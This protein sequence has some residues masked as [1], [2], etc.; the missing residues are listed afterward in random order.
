[1]GVFEADGKKI[2]IDADKCIACGACTEACPMNVLEVVGDICEAPRVADCCQCQTCV[3][4]CPVEAITTRTLKVI[5]STITVDDLRKYYKNKSLVASCLKMNN[6]SPFLITVDN[7]PDIQHLCLGMNEFTHFPNT[8]SNHS[9]L[10]Y[11]DF[12]FNKISDVSPLIDCGLLQTLIL[13]H[14]NIQ[15]IECISKINTLNV[16]DVSYNEI[17]TCVFDSLNRLGSLKINNN[18]LTSLTSSGPLRTLSISNNQLTLIHLQSTQL[19]SLSVCDNP[20]QTIDLTIPS[21]TLLDLSGT[22]IQST[23]M[24]LPSLF[25]LNLISCNLTSL[26]TEFH[27]LKSLTYLSLQGC[28]LSEL[29]DEITF[30]SS[31]KRID[32]SRNDFHVFPSKILTLTTLECL[33]MTNSVIDEYDSLTSLGNL[34]TAMFCCDGVKTTRE[35]FKQRLP[36]NCELYTAEYGFCD[37]IIKG[38]YLGSYP[39]AHNKNYLNSINVTHILTVADLHP[40]FP[41]NFI[42]KCINIDDDVTENISQHFNECFEFIDAARRNGSVF[43]HCAAGVS[44]SASVVIAYLM[45]EKKMSYSKAY[46]HVQNK[47]P[48]IC[49]NQAFREQLIEF[50]KTLESSCVIS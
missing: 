18:Q 37:F 49:P 22:N 43:V 39:N 15:S 46:S 21:L 7:F 41:T 11:L 34:R 4:T 12:S 14:N 20:L 38:L 25:S 2:T 32:M 13:A 48:I 44:R 5:M 42:Y 23:K 50:G 28:C 24:D 6:N 10:T 16:L 30:I 17:S 9:Y 26:Q 40:V 1:M 35:Y 45:K 3:T 47:R 19:Q 36:T 33:D 27:S 8:L 29:P 31:L